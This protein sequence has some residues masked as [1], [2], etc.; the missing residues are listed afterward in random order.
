MLR[1]V[2]FFAAAISLLKNTS[3]WE[4]QQ[5]SAKNEAK[6]HFS[7]PPQATACNTF[8]LGFIF[9]EKRER[10]K[11]EKKEREVKVSVAVG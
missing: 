3:P 1:V 8:L 2:T 7:T 10:S 4:Q 5:K 11:K 6:R 9:C